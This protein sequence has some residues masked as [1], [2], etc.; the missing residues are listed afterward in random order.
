MIARLAPRARTLVGSP[1][2]WRFILCRLCDLIGAAVLVVALA[3]YDEIAKSS[4]SKSS[5]TSS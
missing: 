2:P 1:R 5:Y 3:F 4:Y